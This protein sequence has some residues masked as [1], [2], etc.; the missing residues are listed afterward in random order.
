[1]K[2]SDKK[3][4]VIGDV[5][6]DKFIYCNV[7]RICPEAPVPILKPIDYTQNVGMAGNVSNN[8]LALGIQNK[9]HTTNNGMISDISLKHIRYVDKKTNH[10]FFRIDEGTGTCEK[11]DINDVELSKFDAI[12]ISDYD[13]GFLSKRDISKICEIHPLTFLDTRKPIGD[14]ASPTYFKINEHEWNNSNKYDKDNVIVT[15]GKRGSLFNKS[16]YDT[17]VQDS[18]D[19][20][21]AGDTFISALVAAYLHDVPIE[22]CIQVAN[23]TASHVVSK[24]GVSIPDYTIHELM[25]GIV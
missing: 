6:I 4:L 22:K 7:D 1:M 12:I 10:M 16:I 15:L 18:F 2:I 25:D 8:L 24:K 21:G 17:R 3:V 9:L 13:K 20:S 11:F 5:C 23:Y 19:I 14:W